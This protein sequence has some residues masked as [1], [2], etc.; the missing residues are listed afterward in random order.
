MIVGWKSV[1]MDEFQ[2]TWQGMVL[3]LAKAAGKWRLWIYAQS[4]GDTL[5]INNLPGAAVKGAWTEPR[6]A[7]EAVDTAMN[8]VLKKKMATAPLAVVKSF[9]HHAPN[10]VEVEQARNHSKYDGSKSTTVTTIRGDRVLTIRGG[11]VLEVRHV[12]A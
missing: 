2:A 12:V 6:A 8:R 11:R 7:M 3:T 4:D 9:T 1:N 5:V 10:F